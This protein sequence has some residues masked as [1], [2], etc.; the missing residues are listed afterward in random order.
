MLWIL[1]SITFVVILLNCHFKERNVEEN[2]RL[3][4]PVIIVVFTTLLSFA[5]VASYKISGNPA[6][7]T[8]L[9]TTNDAVVSW[10]RWAT[11]LAHNFYRPYNAGYPVLFPGIWSLIY[12]AQ[13]TTD[14]WFLTKGSLIII[15]VIVILCISQFMERGALFTW[16]VGILFFGHFFSRDRILKSLGDGHMDAPVAALMLASSCLLISALDDPPDRTGR[17]LLTASVSWAWPQS[18]SKRV[19]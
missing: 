8:I 9:Y 16:I 10:N 1:S 6:L 3:Y 14:I 11:E 18:P 19:P 4:L 13:G 12:K 2:Y 7:Y 5:C 15:P 17:R